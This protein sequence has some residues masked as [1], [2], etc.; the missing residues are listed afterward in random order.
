MEPSIEGFGKG[1]LKDAKSV[2]EMPGK[3]VATAASTAASF[4]EVS[5][6]LMQVGAWMAKQLAGVL[7]VIQRDGLIAGI[8]EMIR[9]AI[10]FIIKVAAVLLKPLKK[11]VSA[12]F[13]RWIRP[14]QL[15]ILYTVILVVIVPLK[16][17]LAIVDCV[18]G[19]RLRF[20]DYSHE[21]PDAWWQRAGFECGNRYSR[22]VICWLP[23]HKGYLPSMGGSMCACAPADLPRCSPAALLVRHYLWGSFRDWGRKLPNRD[24]EALKRFR[25]M[26]VREYASVF[27]EP[28]PGKYAQDLV[29]CL[30]LARD[31]VFSK[32]TGIDELAMYASWA[33][34]AAGGRV[35]LDDIADNTVNFDKPPNATAIPW[36]PLIMITSFLAFAIVVA[37]RTSHHPSF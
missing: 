10:G 7:N 26:C 35:L 9:L 11:S 33:T 5:T 14:I 25:R 27:R 32:V 36:W 22:F 12:F 31:A 21:A 24:A 8:A 3:A 13:L 28:G 1:L 4:A 20:L 29:E 17:I 23:C 34:H 19:G 37:M 6:Q 16:L 2:F 15:T 30:I 18:L